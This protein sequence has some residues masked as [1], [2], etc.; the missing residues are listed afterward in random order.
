MLCNDLWDVKVVGFGLARVFMQGEKFD[1]CHGSHDYIAPEIFFES[2][3]E[4][5]P[6]DVWALGILFTKLLVGPEFSA[7]DIMKVS[8]VY[9]DVMIIITK[10]CHHYFVQSCFFEHNR[11]L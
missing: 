4:G 9:N 3:H 7:F 8:I 2:S 6:V 1:D 5:P 10:T 11:S